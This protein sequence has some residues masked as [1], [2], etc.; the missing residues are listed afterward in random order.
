M[1]PPAPRGMLPQ[2]TVKAVILGIIL[3]IVMAAA[4]AYL[5]LFTGMT[6][7]A[8]IPAAVISMGVLRLF[9]HSNIIENNIVQTGAS[10]GE[11]LAA[12]AIF[13]LPALIL[14]HHWSHFH[15]WWVVGL[16]GAGGLLGVLFTIPLRRSLI[17]DQKLAFPEGTA[18]AEV[19][20]VGDHPRAGL[21][22]LALAALLGALA[23]LATTGLQLF[24][25]IAVAAGYISRRAVGY[26][27]L[28]ISPALLGV[29]YIVG[30]NIASLVFLGGAISWFVAI[31]IFGAYFI[32]TDPQLAALAAT[33]PGAADLAREIWS[34]QI[35]YLGVGAMLVGGLWALLSLRAS[36]F[37]GIKGGLEQHRAGRAALANRS[38]T[39]KD[40]PM[41]WVLIAVAALVAPLFY[42]FQSITGALVVSLPM[43]G[44]MLVAAFLFASVG[45]YMAGLVGSSNNPISGITITTILF[46]ALVLLWLMGARS[47]IGPAAAILIG[48]VVCSAAAIAGDNLQDLKAG[49]LIGATAWKLQIMQGVGV[50]SAVLVMAPILNLLLRAYGF[51]APTTLHPQALPAPQ[52]SLMAAVAQGVFGAGLPWAMIGTG[53]GIGI[54]VIAFDEWLKYRKAR[55]RAPVLAVAVGS[56][57][58][59]ELATPIFLGGLVAYGARRYNGRRHGLGHT[60]EHMRRGMLFA[61]GLI[62]GEALLG[63]ALAV[64]IVITH[65]ANVVALPEAIR[66]GSWLGLLVIVLI[67]AGLARV[68]MRA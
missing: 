63:I 18:T 33:H 64:P 52:A 24:P 41:Q 49:H 39:D 19:L 47:T 31:P 56:Y 46:A 34:T 62:T 5:G 51:G 17:V 4:N 2:L 6:V 53:A 61:A 30:L 44:I 68:A 32:T 40:I 65:D 22:A 21:N 38:E 15:Y 8:S 14:L 10:A 12:G 11:A 54:A 13:T 59:L 60:E 66:Q 29:G 25:G 9:R 35:R 16:T 42:L 55:W 27:G 26:V 57:L 45:G 20:K 1:L 58:P 7:S 50:V 3:A 36:L 67:A 23:K 28:H 48:A 43:T 37:V